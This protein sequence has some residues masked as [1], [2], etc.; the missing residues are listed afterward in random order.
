MR[1]ALGPSV[2]ALI[3][4]ARQSGGFVICH[5]SL[6]AWQAE[7]VRIRPSI[8]SGYANELPATYA[9]R[10]ARAIGHIEYVDPPAA[11]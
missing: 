4:E 10:V 8:C 11:P 5:E 1:T 9:L 7:E 2:P 3:R 6:E